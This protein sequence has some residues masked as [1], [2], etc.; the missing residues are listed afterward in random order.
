MQ[1]HADIT[2]RLDALSLLCLSMVVIG[3]F[4]M[5]TVVASFRHLVQSTRFYEMG[6]AVLQPTALFVGV[7]SS[8]ALALTLFTLLALLTLFAAV[9]APVMFPHR[10]AWLAGWAP[11]VLMLVC[12][13][14]LYGG[15]AGTAPTL[16]NSGV[17]DNLMRIANHLLQHAQDAAVS[18]LSVGAGG[19][20]S[21]LASIALAV[22]S[23]RMFRVEMPEVS[24]EPAPF[25]AY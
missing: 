23:T 4:G 9:A 16:T 13:G 7:G 21:A 11:L 14:L 17:H 22:R 19:V 15:G 20:L 3:W 10:S 2:K 24:F 8:H 5:D 12:A 6:V 18:H 1:R 25:Y